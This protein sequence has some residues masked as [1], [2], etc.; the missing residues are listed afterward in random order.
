MVH[1]KKSLKSIIQ[2]FIKDR[3]SFL[4]LFIISIVSIIALF[5]LVINITNNQKLFLKDK[6]TENLNQELRQ[7]Y[8]K[9]K[10]NI[11]NIDLLISDSYYSPSY[12][13][14]L[15]S[16]FIDT[17]FIYNS[18]IIPDYFDFKEISEEE[19]NQ[20]KFLGLT[21][22]FLSIYELFKNENYDNT[23]REA[24][25]QQRFL[26]TYKNVNNK[27]YELLIESHKKLKNYDRAIEYLEEAINYN[28]QNKIKSKFMLKMYI[29]CF[30]L[31]TM[32]AKKKSIAVNII[33][34]RN[35]YYPE[36]NIPE[37]ILNYIQNWLLAENLYFSKEMFDKKFK[38]LTKYGA[39]SMQFFDSFVDSKQYFVKQFKIYG[40]TYYI[41]INIDLYKIFPQNEYKDKLFVYRIGNK[42]S[43][44][45]PDKF[46]KYNSIKLIDSIFNPIYIEMYLESTKMVNYQAQKLY[47]FTIIGFTILFIVMIITFIVLSSFVIKEYK[48]NE[49]K[50]DFISIASHELKT[51]I[52]TIQLAIETFMRNF[53]R[54][55]EK[56]KNSYLEK[57]YG[58]TE[59]LLY[60]INNLLQ[61]SRNEK[62]TS[63]HDFKEHD[64]CEL[65]Y[66]IVDIYKLN[67]KD[68]EI[69][70]EFNQNVILANIDINSFK[71]VIYNLIDNAYKYSEDNKKLWINIEDKG[72]KVEMTFRDN[73]LG[74]SKQDIDNIFDKFYRGQ[75]TQKIPGTGLG[76]SLIK[77]IITFHNGK[78]TV[79]S[80]KGV[81]STFII[82]LFR[83]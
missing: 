2:F 21:D 49:A 23:I 52:T 10:K 9:I 43:H 13:Y 76:L 22:K 74:M 28:I 1:E 6:I 42:Y 55:D 25:I 44:K 81:G 40:A 30:N 19:K 4:F 33:L 75:E 16:F 80:E 24:N 53:D 20:E 5:I 38:M 8:D 35:K 66:E 83:S 48:L 14:T 60:L 79:S 63:K 78:I 15:P 27:Y 73:G 18:F 31:Y 47:I 17:P 70:I 37:N 62:N 3:K 51:P 82:S 29:D 41:F 34:Y 39:T 36:Y 26:K 56:K 61:Y 58:E 68:M 72:F 7:N 54:F 57:I 71:Q 46:R 11:T 69:F 32:D 65:I 77:K 67:R 59:R 45:I 12:I 64:L 50:S